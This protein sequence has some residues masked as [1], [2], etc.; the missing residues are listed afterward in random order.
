MLSGS[1]SQVLSPICQ[2]QASLQKE[3]FLSK[4]VLMCCMK[5]T[6][7]KHSGHAELF[8]LVLSHC[9]LCIALIRHL[10]VLHII[11]KRLNNLTCSNGN[12]GVGHQKIHVRQLRLETLTARLASAYTGSSNQS[13]QFFQM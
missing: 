6:I 5:E 7:V 10:W 11:C 12:T 3:S 8:F 13:M 2:Q 4:I 9:P 1:Y